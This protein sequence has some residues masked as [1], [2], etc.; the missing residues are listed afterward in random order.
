MNCPNIYG[1]CTNVESKHEF[2]VDICPQY[3][4]PYTKASKYLI[5]L[6]VNI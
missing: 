1:E 3:S 2:E 6:T 4:L 5:P